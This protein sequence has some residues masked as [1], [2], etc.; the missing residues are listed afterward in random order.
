MYVCYTYIETRRELFKMTNTDLV[1][2]VYEMVNDF[3]FD[4]G[5]Y[6]YLT[7][8]YN[9]REGK[10]KEFVYQ[11][12]MKT[13]MNKKLNN[14]KNNLLSYNGYDESVFS[15]TMRKEIDCIKKSTID[16]LVI[17]DMLNKE[18]N[19][20]KGYLFAKTELTKKVNQMG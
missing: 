13:R 10:R 7:K 11:N 16:E 4:L 8:V 5:Q 3:R 6:K 1:K 20:K 14:Y 18:T 19:F 15:D 17:S 12:K 2:I 9:G